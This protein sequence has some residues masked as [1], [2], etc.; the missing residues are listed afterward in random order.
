MASS[1]HMLTAHASHDDRQRI[2][3][4]AIIIQERQGSGGR[5]SIVAEIAE[6]RHEATSAALNVGR[7]FA[8]S[9]SPLNEVIR[10]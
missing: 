7:C 6:V 2:T 8:H 9:R 5:G 3:A 1:I 4:I 10:K